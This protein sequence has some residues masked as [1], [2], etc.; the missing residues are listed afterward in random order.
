MLFYASWATGAAVAVA[1][2]TD[3]AEP[4]RER[5]RGRPEPVTIEATG[6]T[7]PRKLA[8]IVP[9][10]IGGP[11]GTPGSSSTRYVFQDS[12][13]WKDL[14]SKFVLQLWRDRV[15]FDDP[16][17]VREGWSSVVMA[18]EHLARFDRDG[19][20]L[21]EHEGIPDQTFDTW[22]MTGPSA[23][24][25]GLWISALEAASRM[26]VEVGD[27]D[28]RWPL[29]RDWRRVRRRSYVD[30]LWNG[31]YFLYDGSGGPVS[32]SIMADQLCGQWYADATGLPELVPERWCGPRSRRSSIQRP[33]VSRAG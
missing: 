2:T 5:A 25:G 8:G 11:I 13:R 15:L 27:G 4:D 12:T 24:A 3:D 6:A 30:K 32:D 29:R 7:A 10:D 9:H 18:M 19:D 14:N 26:A 17:L 23:Y 1:R 20:G 22:P 16:A 21:P 31:R 33:R 28:D